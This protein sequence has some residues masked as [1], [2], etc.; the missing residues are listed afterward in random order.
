ML[1]SELLASFPAEHFTR[2]DPYPWFNFPELLRPEAFDAL[3]RDF[4][5]LERFEKHVGIA[6]AHGQ[7]PHDRY[8]LA[9]EQ[10]LYHAEED[11]GGA[12]ID[13]QELAPSWQAFI[14]EL[15][16]P[17]YRS[18]VSR[19][20]GDDDLEQRYA[21][22]LGFR[23]SEVS[24]HQDAL[25]KAGS[26]LFY[27]NTS[28]DWDESWGGQTLV[29]DGKRGES[30]NPDFGD[31]ASVRSSSMLDNHSFLFKNARKAWHG[32]RALDC[33]EQTFRRLFTV[34]FEFGPRQ[35]TLLEK[36]RFRAR[37]LAGR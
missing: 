9:Y 32:V 14:D 1:D 22:H 33:P 25:E 35:P 31:F 20:L 13:H 18:F 29:L 24:P 21:W 36:V 27:F 10:S 15:E 19:L 2:N 4:P 26:H 5:P 7:R 3:V 28:E 16:G 34:V 30:M 17:E 37:K 8:Y 23:G 11:G 12:V 6:R